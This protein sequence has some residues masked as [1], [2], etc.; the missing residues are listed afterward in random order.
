MPKQTPLYALHLAA[1]AKL[2][3][4]AGWDMPI[5]YGS[6]LEEHKTV[7]AD[8]GMFDVSH[9]LPVDITGAGAQAFLRRLLAND[10]AKLTEPG[11]AL[12]A[13]MLNESGGVID[14]L[15]VYFFASDDYRIVVNAGT[16]DKDVAWMREV[17]RKLPS[18]GNVSITPHRDL[19]I[20]AVQGP[21]AQCKVWAALP[22]TEAVTAPLKYFQAA[23][24]DDLMVCFTGYTGEAGYELIFPA[25]RAA[26][27]WQAL[28]AQGVAPVGLG[29]RD[30]LRLEAGMN[31]YG[32]DMDETV[33]PLESG[34]G[35]TVNFAADH[36]FIGRSALQATP[37]QR[38][39]VGLLLEDRGILRSHMRVFTPHGEGETTSGSFAPSLNASIAFARVPVAVAIGDT[40]EVDIRGKR[41]PAR[42]VKLPF[43]RRGK[44][45]V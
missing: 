21:N 41:L 1:G 30:T 37:P 4:F 11:K 25:E 10:V 15:I 31:L 45:L 14:D 9:M 5:H 22:G 40:V 16:A 44:I 33:G 7:R 38:Q 13:C 43:V 12:Y 6:Q 35:W 28:A 3:D 42:V 19:A 17:A 18:G 2:V 29:A 26:S 32:A 23:R 8:A 24:L 36:D 34:L 27:V 39:L 20:I